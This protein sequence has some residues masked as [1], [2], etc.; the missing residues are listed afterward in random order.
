MFTPRTLH[1]KHLVSVF[2]IVI[3]TISSMTA[4]VMFIEKKQ[5]QETELERIFYKADAMRTRLGH[6][7][8]GKNWRYLMMTLSNAKAADP[9]MLYF[10]ITG[11]DGHVLIAD[12]P[13][14]VGQERFDLT[15]VIDGDPLYSKQDTGSKGLFNIFL[16]QYRSDIKPGDPGHAD[17]GEVIFEAVYNIVYLGQPMG[18]FRTGFSRSKINRHLV[19]LTSGMLGTGLLVLFAVLTIIYLVIRRHMI[20][21]DSFIR[22][23]SGLDL[24]RD[25]SSFRQSL[26]DLH[27]GERSGETLDVRKLKQAFRHL[28]GQFVSA[29][30][31]LENHR[32]NLEQMVDERTLA[33]NRSNEQLS[34]QISERKEIES[35]ILTVQKLEA[36]GTLAGGVAHEFNNLFMAISGY[37]TLIQKHSDSGHPNVEKAEKIRRLVETGAS[38]VQQLLGFARSGKFD[39]GPMNLN[40]ILR[41]SLVIL[42]S[43][44]KELKIK[45]HYATNL[46]TV[47]ADRSQMEQASMNL[48]LNAAEAM[49]ASGTIRIRTQNLEL[50]NFQVSLDKQMSGRFVMLSVQDEGPGIDPDILPR[51]FDPFF[52]TKAMGQGSGMGLASVF[53]I[54]EN[55]G[56]FTTAESKQ[57]CGSTF[58]IYLPALDEGSVDI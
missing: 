24:S 2:L 29:W 51:I 42:E 18:Q 27:L 22:H 16:S 14:L 21:V 57:N 9:S 5:Y 11:V 53:G 13:A 55:H 12:D 52:T 56:G 26:A 48:L 54:V 47:Q 38:S 41:V 25:G 40:E 6:L 23:I 15:T 28:R 34:R 31:Q 37:A 33:L 43:S 7:M 44:R 58:C 39:P 46:W 17:R 3:L 19:F 4:L 8:Y 35:R 36:I 49:P 10:V 50:S 32:D 30:D 1:A 20:P 45:T